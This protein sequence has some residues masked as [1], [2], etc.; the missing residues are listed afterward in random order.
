MC[1]I[2]QIEP[3]EKCSYKRE[4]KVNCVCTK[5]IDQCLYSAP[6]ILICDWSLGV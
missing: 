2:M 3:D 6:L 5:I 4:L 1:A